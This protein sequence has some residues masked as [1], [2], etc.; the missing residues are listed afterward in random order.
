[1]TL[2]SPNRIG[3]LEQSKRKDGYLGVKFNY[4]LLL[5]KLFSELLSSI[6]INSDSC[7]SWKVPVESKRTVALS[8]WVRCPE[9]ARIEVKTVVRCRT[10]KHD[11][12]SSWRDSTRI[13]L[14][15]ELQTM[16]KRKPRYLRISLLLAPSKKMP[17]DSI[18]HIRHLRL[19]D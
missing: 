13:D 7:E 1:M 5:G 16:Q 17:P 11:V 14:G 10:T 6:S 9:S 12:R 3:F 19:Y 18:R 4:A 15:V 8:K 2:I